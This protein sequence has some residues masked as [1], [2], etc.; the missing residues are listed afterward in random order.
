MSTGEKIV[1]LIAAIC[2]TA[3]LA[4]TVAALIR[5]HRIKMRAKRTH[6]NINRLR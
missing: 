2:V 6:N 3:V 1:I 4:A 5:N